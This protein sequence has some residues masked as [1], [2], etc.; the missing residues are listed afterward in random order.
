VATDPCHTVADCVHSGSRLV[1]VKKTPENLARGLAMRRTERD[2][3]GYAMLSDTADTLR[4]KGG[5][6]ST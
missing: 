2:A 6:R 1:K 4:G 3:S 5:E